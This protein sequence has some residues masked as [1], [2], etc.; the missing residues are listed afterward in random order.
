MPR[1]AW[2]A[3]GALSAALAGSAIGAAGFGAASAPFALLVAVVA[4]AVAVAA[5][6]LGSRR[7]AALTVGALL[8]ALRLAAAGSSDTA[9][10]SA[11]GQRD[12]DW[13]GSV[14]AISAPRDG[15]QVAFLDLE[16]DEPGSTAGAVIRTAATLPRYPPIRPGLRIRLA[17]RLEDLPDD[18][19]G[20]YL[21]RSGVAATLRAR[22]LEVTGEGAAPGDLVE[23]IRRT[24]DEALARA[25]P[26]PEAGLASGIIIGLRERVDRDLAAAFTAAGVSH[27]VAISGWNIAIV[28]AT[29]AAL[30]RRWPRRRRSAATLLAVAAYTVLTGASASVLRAAAMA[31]VVLLA[32]ESGRAGRAAAALGWAI[33]GL[34]ATDPAY[35]MDPGFALSAAATGGLIVWAS[36]LTEHLAR[37]QSGRLP[38]WLCESLAV[39]IAAEAA[40][41]PIAMAW[42]G[43]FALLAPIVNLFVVPLVAPAMAAG[44]L[45]LVAGAAVMV[46]APGPIAVVVGL[47]A[48]AALA[49]MV[50][51]VRAF[52]ALPFASL[53]LQPP[54]NIAAAVAAAGLV[55]A[56]AHRDR[57]HRFWSA[58][59]G[60][61]AT[62]LH[63]LR[64]DA[65]PGA[66][67]QNRTR[68]DAHRLRLSRTS[69]LIGGGLAATLAALV[70][71]AATRPD[72]SVHLTV[73]DVGQ[74][75]AILV[76]GDRGGRML[77]DGGPDPDRLLVA[78]DAHVPPWDR[79][80]DL[81]ILT[82]PHEDHVGGLAMLLTRYRVG[83]VLEPGMI[84]PGPGYRAWQAGLRLLGTKSGRVATGDRFTLDGVGF[85]V[86]WPDRGSVPIEPA[87][88]GTAINNVSIVMLGTFGR[89]PQGR[90]PRQSHL[91]DGR[92]PR[93]G[94]APDRSDLGRP[95][96]SVRASGARDHRSPASARHAGAPDGPERDS[97]GVAQ[98]GSCHGPGGRRATA[99]GNVGAGRRQADL[100]CHR[101]RVQRPEDGRPS[102]C[103]SS[104]ND[105]GCLGAG[106]RDGGPPVPSAR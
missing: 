103:S 85:L 9:D 13:R 91:L 3:A 15:R 51:I 4:A 87:D 18:D 50:A 83:S 102:G 37:W 35:V 77:V 40:T 81:I 49:P 101:N 100:A 73:L 46:G 69:R 8:V 89:D 47:P 16:P 57:L 20:R 74:G 70:L 93:C 17:G 34:L 75:D 6:R 29:V 97:R 86:L 19:Y 80:L 44:G 2:V 5:S 23:R 94:S 26:E 105:R 104:L 95:G 99:A 68:R 59:V 96:Q 71:V 58:R 22:S 25:L 66:R 54:A 12:G 63:G 98:R 27:V 90:P 38:R 14:V 78:L 52:A 82:H 43:R 39:S 67:P 36:P 45:A 24:G 106:R 11:G 48:W 56:L 31:T 53:V 60:N 72:G 62:G 92:L 88:G 42:F 7:L 76:E 28:G 33:V 1:S 32:R 21:A 55:L 79:R 61:E 10:P 30:V 64:V 84:G 41:L 65:R